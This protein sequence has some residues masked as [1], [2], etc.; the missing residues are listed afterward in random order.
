MHNILD[1]LIIKDTR[2]KSL[3][4][5][6]MHRIAICSKQGQANLIQMYKMNICRC[7]VRLHINEAMSRDERINALAI[8]KIAGMPCDS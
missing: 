7:Y 3:S 6:S 2:I 4:L 8:L 5:I 1:F